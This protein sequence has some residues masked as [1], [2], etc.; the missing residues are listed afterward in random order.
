[1]NAHIFRR[2][3]GSGDCEHQLGSSRIVLIQYGAIFGRVFVGDF[4]ST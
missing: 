3:R 2:K 1:M 4:I